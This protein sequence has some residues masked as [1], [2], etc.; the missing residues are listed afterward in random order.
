MT[1]HH[2]NAMDAL[3]SVFD[4]IRRQVERDPAFGAELL[5]ALRVPVH[6]RIENSASVQGAMLFLDPVVIAGQGIDEFLKV[7]GAM[8][9]PDKKKVIRAYNLAP[10]EDLMGRTAPKGQALAELMWNAA[11]AKRKRLE[12]RR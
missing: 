4:T 8:K 10:P 1:T 2:N 9:D 3:E 7:F 5:S 12:E 6:I 11:C